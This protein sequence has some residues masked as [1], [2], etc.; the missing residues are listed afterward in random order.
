MNRKSPSAGEPSRGDSG[1]SRLLTIPQAAEILA[2][3]PVTVRSWLTKGLLPRTKIGRCV[4]IPAASIGQ[5]IQS[6]TTPA[7]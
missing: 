6:N 7:R 2:V 5:F 1:S 3:K 4:R